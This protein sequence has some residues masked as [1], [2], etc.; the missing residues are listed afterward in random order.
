MVCRFAFSAMAVVGVLSASAV[1]K[2]NRYE[3]VPVGAIVP[4]G[5]LAE[6]LRRQQD[7][8]TGHREKLGYPFDDAL[9]SKPI[10]NIHF[11]E[12]VYNGAEEEVS[13]RGDWWNSGAWWPYEQSAYLLDGMARLSNLIEAPALAD[14][15]AANVKSVIA[16]ATETGDLFKN[17]LPPSDSQWPLAVFFRAA[18]A[19]A[20]KT[21]DKGVYTAF[22]R[23]FDA[24]KE[25]RLRWG[26]RDLVNLEGM[27]K[28][29]EV[30]GDET[31]RDD[32]VRMFEAKG[33]TNAL[34][35]HRRY[36]DHG[37]SFC[38][39]LKLPVLMYLYTGDTNSL[40]TAE[41]ALE[42]VFRDNVQ[43]SGQISAN[44]FLSGRDP[45]QGF[46]TCI[47]ADMLWTL[48]YFLQ[49]GTDGAAERMERIAYNALPGAMTKDFKRHQYLSAVNQ[50]ACTPFANNSHFNYAESAWRQY[51]P[52]HFPQCCTGN[53]NRAMPIFVEYLWMTDAKTGEPIAT[54][55]G[56]SEYHGEK[57]GVKYTIIEDT[58]YPFEDT[59]RF[60]LAPQTPSSFS[61]PITI[62]GE[63]HMLRAGETFVYDTKPAIRL[64]RDRNWCWIERGPLTFSFSVPNVAKEDRPGDPFSPVSFTPAGDWNYAIEADAFDASKL[65]VERRESTYPFESPSLAI[66]VPVRKIREWQVLDQERFTPDPPL[67][68]HL[69]DER[70]EIELVPYATTTTRIT[71]FPDGVE[72]VRL[73]VVAAYT[74]GESYPYDPYRPIEVQ[75]NAVEGWSVRQFTGRYDVPQRTPEVWFDLMHRYPEGKKGGRMAYLLF[76]VWSDEDGEATFCLGAA[77]AYQAWIDG[78]EVARE[79]GPVEGLM[80][81]PQWFDHK[82]K[83]GYNYVLVKVGKGTWMGQFRSEWGAKLEVFRTVGKAASA[84]EATFDDPPRTCGVSAWWHWLGSNVSKAG[85]TRDLE[86]MRS[87]GLSGATIFNI[88]ETGWTLNEP[89]LS[90]LEPTM[91]YKNDKW[92]EMLEYAVAEAK[93]LGLELGIHNSPGYSSSGGTWITPELAIKKLV[94]CREGEEPEK[95]RGFYRDI[96]RIQT[97][98]GVYRFGYTCT[99]KVSHPVPPEME[100]NCLEADKLSAEA[101]KV[102]CDNLLAGLLAHVKPSNP[103]LCFLMEDSYEAGPASWTDDF[104][105]EFRRRRGYDLI[106]WLPVLAGLPVKG[107]EA[108]ERVMH[109][110][111]RTR[112]EL[113]TE[114]HYRYFRERFNAAGFQYHLEPYTGPF[115]SFEAT[116]CPDVPMTEFWKGLPFWATKPQLG[117]ATWMCGP[118]CRALGGTVVGAEAFTGYPLDDKFSLTPRDLK[119]DFDASMARGLNRLSLHHWVHQPLDPRWQPGF[120]MGAWGTHFGENQTWFEPGKDFYR[121]MGR[122]QAM[123]RRGEMVADDLGVAYTIGEDSDALPVSHF[124]TNTAV[125]A[126]GRVRVL[127]S[128]KEYPIVSLCPGYTDPKG[129]FWD[130]MDGEVRQLA[131]RYA[132]CGVVLCTDGDK[133]AARKRAGLGPVFAVL[134]GPADAAETVLANARR[135]GDVDFFFVC[136]TTREP[137]RLQVEFR[138][139]RA[140]VPELWFPLSGR[141][142]VASAWTFASAKACRMPLSLEAEESVFVVFRR[143]TDE[144]VRA[145]PSTP[146]SKKEVDLASW[147]MEF[148]PDRGAPTNVIHLAE[149]KD[150]T[151]FG[152]PGIRYFS[153]TAVY[154]SEVELEPA[155]EGESLVL[156]LGK[157]RDIAEVFVNGERAGVAWCEPFKLDVTRFVHPG[158]NAI[159]VRVTN[160]WTNRLIGDEKEPDDGVRSQELCSFREADHKEIALGRPYVRFPDA[161]L[162]NTPRTVKRYAF[163]SWNYV[164]GDSDLRES[165]LLGPVK[166]IRR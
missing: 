131:H 22:K 45:R 95:V 133:S 119:A 79:Q 1:E 20:E 51:R 123:M 147:R 148:Q 58:D 49:A 81:A 72:R 164:L 100:R 165:G 9:W 99:G 77:N 38:E 70:A 118:V 16:G 43:A 115:N 102:H 65:K 80:M 11:T 82:V 30:T 33:P 59:V 54:L 114:R 57:D 153:G 101:M 2:F 31:L 90:S 128:G 10:S 160:A 17:L 140:A 94:W 162:S 154:R 35:T 76:R 106:P 134:E 126:E 4:K 144:L 12:G 86:A 47:A 18:D 68:A 66:R 145:E 158:R 125:T 71:C 93:R 127:S 3:K 141:K 60:T 150:W 159:E 44:E 120:S 161:V 136:N 97:T 108:D 23:H 40:A 107:G 8:L 151:T 69:T 53:I 14:E 85:I 91:S 129:P 78:E 117:G 92:W 28:C 26:G 46:E 67:S 75:T 62:R 110:Y 13:G 124:L 152:E 15:V 156:A 105:E 64:R 39:A 84:L 7:G 143:P 25:D 146:T 5:H 87:A 130:R 103:G 24:H 104:P 155:R 121:Y 41:A 42:K 89:F 6:F 52:S 27:L 163:A 48:G 138:T 61:I 55:L 122:V 88:Q 56:P 50:V 36:F 32:A 98:N 96:A 73:P 135:D 29:Y 111:L 142:T 166:I 157:V 63:R 113:Q 109:D 149:L 19:F 74:S 132:Q 139:R 21:G 116:A 37:V 137:M 112:D 83:K 34:K